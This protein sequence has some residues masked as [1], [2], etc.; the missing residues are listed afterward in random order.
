MNNEL[1]RQLNTCAYVITIVV[2]IIYIYVTNNQDNISDEEANNL[3]K[4]GR[5]LLFIVAL[6]FV[7]NAFIG[8]K[9]NKSSSQYKQV[10]A[11]SLAIL[12]ALIRLTIT[13][14]DITFR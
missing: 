6:Y 11:A 10:L 3:V 12:A 1:E 13:S 7:I 8:Y 5:T 4:L 2:E 14:D 9:N